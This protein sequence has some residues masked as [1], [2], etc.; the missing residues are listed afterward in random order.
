MTVEKPSAR[1]SWPANFP[2][3]PLW[4]ER[5]RFELT[6]PL[7]PYRGDNKMRDKSLVRVFF[8][9][10]LLAAAVSARADVFNMPGGQTSLQF[11][12]VRDPGNIGEQIRLQYGDSTYYGAV[13]STYQMGKYDVT[14]GQ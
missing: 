10:A 5:L 8:A 9:A 11:V 3:A 2:C 4:W 13:G 14:V 7:I 12:T 1:P 6:F